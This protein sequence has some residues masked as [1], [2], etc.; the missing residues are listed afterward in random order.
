MTRQNKLA[1]NTVTSLLYEATAI[2]CGF[3]MPRFFLTCYGSRVNGLV[4]SVTQFLGFITLAECGVGDRDSVALN[5]CFNICMVNVN[6]TGVSADIVVLDIQGVAA[7]A[8]G[9][10]GVGIVVT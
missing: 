10:D 8:L 4:T 2:V 9:K 6:A 7:F 1:L 5:N 3:V